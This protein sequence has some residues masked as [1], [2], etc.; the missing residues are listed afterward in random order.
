MEELP[1]AEFAVSIA[2]RSHPPLACRRTFTRAEFEGLIRPL[3]DRSIDKCKAA[4]RDAGMTPAK[5]PSPVP[6]IGL[7]STR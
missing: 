5:E 7:S 4:L 2:G 6:I 3:I 1:K